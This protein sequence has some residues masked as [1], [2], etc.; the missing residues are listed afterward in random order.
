MEHQLS[1]DDQDLKLAREIGSAREQGKPLFESTDPLVQELVAYKRKR[2]SNFKS[3]TY[4]S[5]KQTVWDNIELA[6]RSTGVPV[7]QLINP[8]TA[9]RWVVAATI[10]I[11]AIFSFTYFHLSNQTTLLAQSGSAI[12]TVQL[13]D[14]STVIMRPYSNLYRV[15]NGSSSQTYHLQGEGYFKV[16]SDP[17]RTFSV[18]TETG[19]ISVL[20][21]RFVLS[22]WGEQTQ[23]YLEEGSVKVEALE[24]DSAVI[25]QPGESAF[26]RD[27]K[28]VPTVA[29]A[30]TRE[31]L[32]WI[33]QQLIFKDKPAKQVAYELEQQ[34]NIKIVLP[35]NTSDIIL[36]GQLSLNNLQ[37]SLDDLELVLGGKFI[38]TANRSYSFKKN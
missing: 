11:A 37:T 4:L 29:G 14:G 17:A 25:I 35:S 5:Q 2:F 24:Q 16:A 33:N 27:K 13:G 32:D 38:R 15:K 26:V 19:R 28:A 10:L 30:K 7:T 20:G 18:E 31:F 36:T 8:A 23:V 34:F 6:T 22:T 21:T 3:Q 9:M 12:E 1:N